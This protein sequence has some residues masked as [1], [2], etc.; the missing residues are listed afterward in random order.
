MTVF[1]DFQEQLSD[2]MADARL[3]FDSVA[4]KGMIVR[5]PFSP[6]SPISGLTGVLRASAYSRRS[7][8]CP[9]SLASATYSAAQI[10]LASEYAVL[11]YIVGLAIAAKVSRSRSVVQEAQLRLSFLGTPF[12]VGSIASVG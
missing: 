11:L 7:G 3:S 12:G 10:S 9:L 5:R 4:R 2:D 1:S 8:T 6:I